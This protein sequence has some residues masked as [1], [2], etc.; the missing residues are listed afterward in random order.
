[1]NLA[2]IDRSAWAELE[3]AAIDPQSGF[4]FVNLCSVDGSGRPQARMVVLRQADAEK[5]T[6]EIHT[7][8]RSG[9]WL[10]IAKNSAATVLGFSAASRTQL[11][12]QGTA[13]LHAPGSPI[14][15]EAWDKLSPWTRSTYAGGPPGDATDGETAAPANPDDDAD[16]KRFFGVVI[17]T[18][19]SLDWFELRRADNRRAVFDYDPAGA[20][21]DARWVNP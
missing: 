2:E 16:G 1:M 4:R 3:T 8:I 5:R 7:D 12:L 11:R 9:K 18:A 20:L 21:T 10:E 15:A 14:A 6:L 13:R 19:E 17:F